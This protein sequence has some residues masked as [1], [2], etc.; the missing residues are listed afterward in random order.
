MP[1][2]GNG[3]AVLPSFSSLPSHRLF[4]EAIPE[5]LF[6][7]TNLE[8][9]HGI[10]TSK[11][12]WLTKIQ[13]LNDAAEL[14]YALELF[15]ARVQDWSG[16][17]PRAA[18]DFLLETARQLDS[19]L[20][21]NICLASFCTEGDLLSQWR[22][23]SAAANGVSLAF[24]GGF[25]R[26]LS[27]HENFH[28]WKCLYRRDQHNQVI[29]DLIALLLDLYHDGGESRARDELMRHFSIVFLQVAPVLK[30]PSFHEEK[31]WRIISAPVPAGA[32]D[33]HVLLAG[34]RLRPTYQLRFPLA[35]DGTCR[36]LVGACTGPSADTA[37][38]LDALSL[39]A[40]LHGHADLRVQPSR[41]P[42][43]A[44]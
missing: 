40:G 5:M 36:V 23:Y 41:I 19:F 37:L 28:I 21:A 34:S 7:Y 18:R 6:H 26:Q 11:Q 33:Y 31:E 12:I 3:N 15:R 22:A 13:H 20:N 16:D 43:R 32:A 44:V 2:P 4:A 29:E 9:A 25:L 24:A 30:H 39:L 17:L 10:L 14:R 42:F 8:G 27:Q 1:S 35:E 38:M